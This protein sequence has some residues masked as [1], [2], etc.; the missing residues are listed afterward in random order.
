M[1]AE[2]HGPSVHS[3]S[4]A[5]QP[6]PFEL[7]RRTANNDN[8]QVFQHSGGLCPSVH[9]PSQGTQVE[10][11]RDAN[12]DDNVENPQ[13]FTNREDND[14]A[15]PNGGLDQTTNEKDHVPGMMRD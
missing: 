2:D 11:G 3:P 1:G 8:I 10:V 5:I 4:Q 14:V 12:N 6:E 13:V 9:S 15:E 7:L